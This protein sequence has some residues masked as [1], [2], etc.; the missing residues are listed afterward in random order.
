MP[1]DEDLAEK[2]VPDAF[3]FYVKQEAE[4]TDPGACVRV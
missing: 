3:A 2:R 4:E 1:T